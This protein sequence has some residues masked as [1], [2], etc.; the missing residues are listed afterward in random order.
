MTAFG[1][2]GLSV[3]A[4]CTD[5]RI[6]RASAALLLMLQPMLQM[7]F[8]NT[9]ATAVLEVKKSPMGLQQVSHPQSVP[10]SNACQHNKLDGLQQQLILCT[11]SCAPRQH[12]LQLPVLCR[13]LADDA[14]FDTTAVHYSNDKRQPHLALPVVVIMLLLSLLLLLLPPLLT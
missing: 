11:A 3:G 10:I 8:A 14:L 9:S 4:I 13:C 12:W 6:S 5:P 2:A 1:I 7:R